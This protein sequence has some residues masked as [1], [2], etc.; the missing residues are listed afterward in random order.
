VSETPFDRLRHLVTVPVVVDGAHEA[1]FVLDTGIGL[2]LFSGRLCA[3]VGCTTN[4]S[5]FSGRRMSGQ[6]VT[7]PLVD[8]PA[9]AMGDAVRRDHVVGILDLAGAG[10]ELAAIDGFLSLAF[11]ETTPFTVDYARGVVVVEPPTALEQRAHGGVVVP[12]HVERDG[13]A[14]V[15]F[16]LLDI[17]GE[18]TVEVEIDMGS[19][20]L[21]L[22]ERFAAGVGVDLDGAAVRRTDGTDETGYAYTRRFATLGGGIRASAAPSISQPAPDVMFQRII[23]DGLVGDAFLRRGVVTY[24]LPRSRIVFHPFDARD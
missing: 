15:A 11:F 23:Y 16:M 22:D 7:V 4:G 13:P 20:C 10:S 24:D 2:T 6:Q 8:A 17:P 9:L 21:I 5:T 14:I 12:I 3:A 1:R 18:T 19:D